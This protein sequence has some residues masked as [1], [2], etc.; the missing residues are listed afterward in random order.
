[1]NRATVILFKCAVLLLSLLAIPCPAAEPPLARLSFWLPPDRMAEFEGVYGQKLAPILMRHGLVASSTRG[2]VT[3]DSVFNRLFELESTIELE[4]KQA[5]L[6]A[7]S[8]WTS[9]LVEL[10]AVYGARGPD[11]LIGT[12][13]SVYTVPG[14][15]GK[16]VVAGPGIVTRAGT[17]KGRWHTF[18]VADGLANGVVISM[19]Q[20]TKSS[21]R[22]TRNSS[23]T[24]P[25]SAFEA[26]S[27]RWSRP[28]T[29]RRS[30]PCWRKI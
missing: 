17:G 29:S 25:S 23:V 13:L 14:V 7:D 24:A 27:R 28:P 6:S 10:G 16:T 21:S 3:P 26:K 5:S 30:F 4:K 20:R 8:T 2:R 1:M 22:R 9:M 19:L 11:D 12:E 18:D 15:T